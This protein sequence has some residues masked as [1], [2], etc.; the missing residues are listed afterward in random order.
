L[1]GRRTFPVEE[2]PLGDPE[3]KAPIERRKNGYALPPLTLLDTP[4][5]PLLAASSKRKEADPGDFPVFIRQLVLDEAA[6]LRD[7]FDPG[8]PAFSAIGYRE[9]WA[10]LDGELT[11]DAAIDLNAQR[12]LAFSK[13]QRTW[14]RSEPDITWL[15]ATQGLPTRTA[16]ELVSPLL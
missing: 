12:N 6:G 11:R 16:L 5:A 7:R 15:D 3:P 1:V 13:R 8:L 2:P 4:L 9:A 14:F 10:V